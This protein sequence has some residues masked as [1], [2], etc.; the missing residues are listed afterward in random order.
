MRSCKRQIEIQS[1]K[2]KMEMRWICSSSVCEKKW[3]KLWWHSGGFSISVPLMQCWR[4]NGK[5]SVDEEYVWWFLHESI[6]RTQNT[7]SSQICCTLRVLS[8]SRTWFWWTQRAHSE[9]ALS[10]RALSHSRMHT[11]TARWRA[12]TCCGRCLDGLYAY[13]A[14]TRVRKQHIRRHLSCVCW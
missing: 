9:G 3:K 4:R 1:Q 12:Q 13:A 6:W 8:S 10:S 7:A 11:G 2:D 14:I 5:I